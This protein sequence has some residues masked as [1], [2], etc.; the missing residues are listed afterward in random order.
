MSL[1]Q[2]LADIASERHRQDVKWGADRHHANGTGRAGD[3]ADAR[4][5]QARC[6][7][8][9]ENGFGSWRHILDEEHA[10]V[11]AE[12]DLSKSDPAALRAELIQEAAVA[13]AWIEDLDRQAAAS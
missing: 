1:I 5:A 12:P 10:E 3:A 13:V 9:F 6:E 8:A 4:D 11:N 7:M 2:V